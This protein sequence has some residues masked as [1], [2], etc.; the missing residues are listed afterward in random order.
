MLVN[1]LTNQVMMGPFLTSPQSLTL[2]T[3]HNFCF[4]HSFPILS[5]A[6]GRPTYHPSLFPH[7]ISP[8]ISSQNGAFY[9]CY[10]FLIWSNNQTYNS[11]LLCALHL[12][13]KDDYI[14]YIP[15]PFSFLCLLIFKKLPF[16]N[17]QQNANF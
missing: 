17:G 11:C 7:P 6:I 4:I 12:S 8:L 5:N 15:R 3:H 9:Y 13:Y 2:S 1:W 16:S 14:S 10:Y